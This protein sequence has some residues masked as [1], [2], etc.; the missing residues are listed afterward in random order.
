L[1]STWTLAMTA[2]TAGNC[3]VGTAVDGVI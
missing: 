1:I 3:G 2:S